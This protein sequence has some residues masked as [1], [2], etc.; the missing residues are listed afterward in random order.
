MNKK[1]V[2][3]AL[4]NLDSEFFIGDCAVITRELRALTKKYKEQGY[5]KV[6][7]DLDMEYGE[8]AGYKISGERLESDEELAKRELKEERRKET[9]SKKKENNEPS[10]EMNKEFLEYL[11][12][13]NKFEAQ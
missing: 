4:E 7:V 6:S 11:R 13:K 8:L 10:Q 1:L 3:E 2:V 9:I 12:L 5:T